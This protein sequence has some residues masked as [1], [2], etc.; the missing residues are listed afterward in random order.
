MSSPIPELDSPQ[1]VQKKTNVKDKLKKKKSSQQISAPGTAVQ[2]KNEGTNP[3]WA[4]KPPEG[5]ILLNNGDD[6]DLDW[7]ALNKDDNLELWLIRVP[8]TVKSKYLN[9]LK[10]DLPSSSKWE[11]EN[12]LIGGEELRD[13][14][15]LVPRSKKRGKLYAA[16]KPIARHIV[17]SAHESSVAQTQTGP[18]SATISQN[19]PR[20][21]YPKDVLKHCFMPYGSRKADIQVGVSDGRSTGQ[22]ESLEKGAIPSDGNLKTS[23][24]KKR[25]VESETPKR[26]KKAKTVS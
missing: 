24:S 26:T 1:P 14:S 6:D 3:N 7:D 12:D 13:I 4:Y 19:P 11:G 15:C 23:K 9:G 22:E 25:K 16:P 18:H 5:S 10:V 8:D 17:V 20:H 21:S 2:G